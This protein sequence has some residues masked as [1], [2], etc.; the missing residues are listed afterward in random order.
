MKEIMR[1]S[2]LYPFTGFFKI[3][4]LGFLLIFATFGVILSPMALNYPV[5]LSVFGW[6]FVFVLYGYLVRVIDSSFHGFD[7]LPDFNN[8]FGL[9]VE[10][11]KMSIVGVLYLIPF[12]VLLGFSDSGNDLFFVVCLFGFFLI[13]GVLFLLSLCNMV[14]T[15]KLGKALDFG[16]M[17][18]RVSVVGWGK[19]VAWF[20]VTLIVCLVLF[21]LSWCV[22]Y[23]LPDFVPDFVGVL[24]VQFL[25]LPYV[26]VFVFRSV[27]LF[28]SS[29]DAGYLVC[30]GC[31]GYYKLSSGEFPSDFGDKCE[32]G[33]RLSYMEDLKQ[34]TEVK[35]KKQGYASYFTKRNLIIIGLLILFIGTAAS[36]ERTV[37]INTTLI[38]TYNIHDDGTS[39]VEEAIM[40]I[41]NGTAYIEGEYYI[42]RKQV[43]HGS[44]TFGIDGFDARGNQV[45]AERPFIEGSDPNKNGSFTMDGSSRIKSI[46]IVHEGINGTIKVYAVKKTTKYKNRW[47]ISLW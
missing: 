12:A 9:F 2:L 39:L 38:G 15:G 11:L 43:E 23:A 30:D 21:G 25:I 42:S 34:I 47:N 16:G 3:L 8:V 14:F 32:C 29:T 1:G 33:S 7:K 18:G 20:V 35:D 41:P 31:E 27:S 13:F 26:V 5:N 46:T 37:T 40:V 45:A 28:Y 17:F 19:F 4:V 10:G 24:F 6:V 44:N 36:V 22:V